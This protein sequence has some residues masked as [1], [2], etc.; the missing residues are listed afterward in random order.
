MRKTDH[1]MGAFIVCLQGEEAV[2]QQQSLKLKAGS[3]KK[4]GSKTLAVQKQIGNLSALF[5][6]NE[7]DRVELLDR[8]SLLVASRK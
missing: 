5:S 8:L 1:K 6:N 4:K 2:F 3:Q 7:I